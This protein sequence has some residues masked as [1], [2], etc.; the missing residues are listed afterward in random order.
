MVW[1]HNPKKDT[2]GKLYFDVSSYTL[3]YLALSKLNSIFLFLSR[4]LSELSI[5]PSSS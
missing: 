3:R 1:D 5:T 2:I 4:I